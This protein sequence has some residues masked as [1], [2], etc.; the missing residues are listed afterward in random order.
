MLLNAVFLDEGRKLAFAGAG[1]GVRLID[2]K[3]NKTIAHHPDANGV[4]VSPDERTVAI[5]RAGP[6]CL[7]RDGT[8]DD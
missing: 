8:S 4:F 7:K 6:T 3:S 2:L 1:I 5:T